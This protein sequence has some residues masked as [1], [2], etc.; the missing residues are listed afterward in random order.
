[1]GDVG[2]V[3]G[4]GSGTCGGPLMHELNMEFNIGC[5]SPNGYGYVIYNIS[6]H[7]VYTM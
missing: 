7:I 3:E 5:L 4:V 6:K 1:M 2:S